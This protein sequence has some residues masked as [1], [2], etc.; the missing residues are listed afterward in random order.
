[1]E[2]FPRIKHISCRESCEA[3]QT[4]TVAFFLE[5]PTTFSADNMSPGRET[6][7]G[8][9]ISPQLSEWGR[10]SFRL[11]TVQSVDCHR[12]VFR[13]FVNRQSSLVA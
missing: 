8:P 3:L 10:D 4:S 12:E 13:L 2:T 11:I 5:Q 9:G 7:R 6:S 1:M